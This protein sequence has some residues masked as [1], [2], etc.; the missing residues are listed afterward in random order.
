MGISLEQAQAVLD[1][2]LDKA[3]EIAVP[4]NIAVIDPG[5]FLKAFCSM[6]GAMPGAIELA[7]GKARTAALFFANTEEVWENCKPGGPFP[8][9]E[10]SNGGLVT[11]AGGMLL[12]A[13]NG[14]ILGAMPRHFGPAPC[15]RAALL[16]S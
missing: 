1:A 9:M 2:A 3:L 13:P 4:V 6:D 16:L 7:L 12:K 14:A 10:R 8:G 11:F 15:A 5:C